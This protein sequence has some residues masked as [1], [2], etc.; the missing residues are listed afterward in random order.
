MDHGTAGWVCECVLI[1]P[2]TFPGGTKVTLEEKL[3]DSGRPGRSR[4]DE[5]ICLYDQTREGGVASAFE[6]NDG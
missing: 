6:A 2:R 5:T 1:F 4:G 3:V